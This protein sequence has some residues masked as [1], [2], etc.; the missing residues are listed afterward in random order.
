MMRKRYKEKGKMCKKRVN[1]LREKRSVIDN[2]RV[3]GVFILGLIRPFSVLFL[4]SI[5]G[6]IRPFSALLNCSRYWVYS[7]SF[8]FSL[9]STS[10]MS[11]SR[12]PT[13]SLHSSSPASRAKPLAQPNEFTSMTAGSLR[14]YAREAK[15][16][17]ETIRVELRAMKRESM[18]FQKVRDDLGQARQLKGLAEEALRVAQADV[19]MLEAKVQFLTDVLEFNER[20]HVNIARDYMANLAAQSQRK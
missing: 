7:S 12:T 13:P 3:L 15:T 14:Q 10:A 5:G 17:L 8:C 2:R 20:S 4:S 18:C 11:S 6:S 16:E 9:T 19:R 1:V